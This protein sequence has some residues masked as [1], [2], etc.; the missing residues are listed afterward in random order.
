MNFPIFIVT[1]TQC[2][3]CGGE[4]RAVVFSEYPTDKQMNSVSIGSNCEITQVV[5]I[6]K[7]GEVASSD[8]ID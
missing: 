7:I 8:D 3:D 4:Q 1:A 6:D 5:K 2:N